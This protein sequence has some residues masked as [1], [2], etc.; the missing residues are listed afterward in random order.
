MRLAI[1]AALSLADWSALLGDDQ[2]A[3]FNV[4]LTDEDALVSRLAPIYASERSCP[5]LRNGGHG[6]GRLIPPPTDASA[7]AKLESSPT[8]LLC[9]RARIRS[10][11][12]R[13]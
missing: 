2:I 10:Q 3:A 12:L 7:D 13:G 6:E 1:D 5:R 4:T 9:S 11:R 8:G